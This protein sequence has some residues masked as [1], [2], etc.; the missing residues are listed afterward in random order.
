MRLEIY[1]DRWK[2]NQLF[3]YETSIRD[4]R[5]HLVPRA[6]SGWNA[7]TNFKQLFSNRANRKTKEGNKTVNTAP[8][9]INREENTRLSGFIKS[10]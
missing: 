1:L 5:I 2:K 3:F 4:E 6:L 7:E 10:S 8:F 9:N